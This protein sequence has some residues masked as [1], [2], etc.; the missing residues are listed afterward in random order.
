[1]SNKLDS[2]LEEIGRF[3]SGREERE[4]ILREIRGH[5]LEKAEREYGGISDAAVDKAIGGYGP[6]RRLAEKY[7][8]GTGLIPA[9]FKR[10]LVRYTSIVFAV[11]LILVFI[12]SLTQSSIM[13]FP[14]FI[15]RMNIV[16]ILAYLPM[17]FLFDLGLVGI[18]LHL[19]SRSRSDVRLPWP[20]VGLEPKRIKP[21]LGLAGRIAA[22]LAVVAVT[23]FLAAVYAKHGTLF[24]FSLNFVGMKSLFNPDASRFF[25]LCVLALLSIDSA[26]LFAKIFTA[27]PWVKLSRTVAD[28]AVFALIFSRSL[29]NPFPAG[30]P[31]RLELPL[32][33][34]FTI[35]FIVIAAILAFELIKSIVAVSRRPGSR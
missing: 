25:S 5:I 7:Q 19:V 27:S 21:A 23:V 32:R 22:F 13:V 29:E 3:L 10:Y 24:F 1:M 18:V 35:T 12:G 28:T 33:A 20:K 26:A 4:E 6:P 30:A 9:S 15:P 11:H 17:A 2:Y 14:V 16:E 34:N 8:E 31:S